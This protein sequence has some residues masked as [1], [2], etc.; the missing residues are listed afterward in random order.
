MKERCECHPYLKV[1]FPSRRTQEMANPSS[2][3]SCTYALVHGLG[4]LVCIRWPPAIHWEG[5][6]VRSTVRLDIVFASPHP[7]SFSRYSRHFPSC[8]KIS[9]TRTTKGKFTARYFL[10]LSCIVVLKTVLFRCLY[11]P[12]LF[13]LIACFFH[14]TVMVENGGIASSSFGN[15]DS[16]NLKTPTTGQTPSA[17]P[18]ASTPTPGI[19]SDLRS[20]LNL[21]D[22]LNH[23]QLYRFNNL[24]LDN[25]NATPQQLVELYQLQDKGTSRKQHTSE[26][27][28]SGPDLGYDTD[29]EDDTAMSFG[30]ESEDKPER[31]DKAAA[32]S[33]V[34]Q[35]VSPQ[36]R[37]NQKQYEQKVH[38]VPTKEH[39]FR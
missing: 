32:I 13:P 14:K 36:R 4:S 31:E 6:L 17:N 34:R 37:G 11:I 26:A 30:E 18:Q 8:P 2:L 12:L 16:Q 7:S 38:H 39:G 24:Q 28:T 15:M 33:D 25:P 5:D 9:C 20:A 22:T 19:P 23:L 10:N 29:K 35:S 3:S 21:I 1:P 27:E